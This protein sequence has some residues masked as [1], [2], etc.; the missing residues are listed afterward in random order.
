MNDVIVKQAATHFGKGEPEI[1]LLGN[2][3]IHRTY[4]VSFTGQGSSDPIVLQS[5][6]RHMFK[7]PENIIHNYRVVYENINGNHQLHIPSLMPTQEGQWHW[8]DGNNHFWRATAFVNNSYTLLVPQK[9]E[10]AY[11]TAHCFASFTHSLQH[12]DTAQLKA[13][14]PHFHDLDLRYRQFEQAITTA[15]TERL[16]KSTH[17]IAELRQRKKLVD[18]YQHILQHPSDYRTRV[19]HHDCK[20]SNILLDNQSHQVICPVDLDTVMPGLYFS[21]IGDMIRSMAATRDEESTQWAEIGI[22]AD[23][24][25]AIID[26]YMQGMGDSFTPAEK[27]HIHQAGLMMIY[28]QSLRFVADFLNNDVYYKITYPEQNLNRALNQLIL[29]ERLEEFL[30]TIGN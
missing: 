7:E 15:N 8:I 30:L 10:E 21:D 4:K 28:M 5:I 18:F 24:Y 25:N 12:I 16:L 14:I 11:K 22:H 23:F 19:M 17:V 26:G 1:S 6:N 9:A 2:G 29:L 20:L 13:I 27:E 3:L